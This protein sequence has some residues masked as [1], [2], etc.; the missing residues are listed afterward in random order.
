MP[1]RNVG[2]AFLVGRALSLLRF[3]KDNFGDAVVCIFFIQNMT[4][5]ARHIVIAECFRI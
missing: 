1:T 3:F 2:L 4:C 5:A